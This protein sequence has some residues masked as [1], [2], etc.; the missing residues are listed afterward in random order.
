MS[1]PLNAE[2]A[3][4][5]SEAEASILT[6]D[7]EAHPALA[8]LARLLL[9]TKSIASSKVEGMQVGVRELARAEARAD[10]GAKASPTATEV[11][12]NIDAMEVAVVGATAAELF[13]VDDIIAIHRCLT[14]N[15][16]NSKIAGR[17]RTVI[18]A[19]AR[20]RYVDGLMGFR[21]DEVVEWVRQFAESA[22]HAAR[23][24]HAYV[25]A[26]RELTSRWPSQL[27][28]RADPRVDAAAWALIDILPA[29]PVI[30]APVAAAAT[31]RAKAAVCQALRELEDAGVLA[32]WSRLRRNQSWEAVA[33]LD[34]LA[35]LEAG[36]FPNLGD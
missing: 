4:T 8:P 3:G 7:A 31:H 9:R 18:P 35:G 17:V 30:T 11:V 32:P 6:L 15:S 26:V 34:L 21:A 24:A 33:L 22:A 20:D 36:R 13:S 19:A 16:A 2:V 14:E 1:L 12:A 5:V 29:H 27:A 28:A 10:S 25:K 23:L